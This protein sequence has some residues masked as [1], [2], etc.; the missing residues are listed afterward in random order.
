MEESTVVIA[1]ATAYFLDI[2]EKLHFN[3]KNFTSIS[4]VPVFLKK[5]WLVLLP[6]ISHVP[7]KK[8]TLEGFEPTLTTKI[9]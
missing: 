5:T 4:Y 9:S 6:R 7:H 1:A 3:Q 8:L 2:I